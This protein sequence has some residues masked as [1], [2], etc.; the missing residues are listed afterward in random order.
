MHVIGSFA[1]AL[2]VIIP[3]WRIFERAGLQPALALIVLIPYVGIVVVAL[4]L[5][6]SRWGGQR[7]RIDA[8]GQPYQPDLF[9]GKPR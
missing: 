9:D 3:L 2:V 6:F 5:A 8:Y 1:F 4:I 7:V